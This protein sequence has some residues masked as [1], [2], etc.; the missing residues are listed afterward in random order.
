MLRHRNE[1]G[2]PLAKLSPDWVLL[3]EVPPVCWSH[4][5]FLVTV[6]LG[7]F[8]RAELSAQFPGPVSWSL[9]PHGLVGLVV[10]APDGN[11]ANHGVIGNDC[12]PFG[13]PLGSGSLP[14]SEATLAAGPSATPTRG[15]PQ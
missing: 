3:G 12:Q 5:G 4:Q 9:P 6:S 10:A 14:P 1:L 7:R 13:G 11:A 8:S 2:G 15:D